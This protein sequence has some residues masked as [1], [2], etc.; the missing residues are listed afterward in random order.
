MEFITLS[1]LKDMEPGAVF[2]KGNDSDVVWLAVRGG[3]HDW[4]MYEQPKKHFK[5]WDSLRKR[6]EK[7][8]SEQT[9]RDRI[10]CDD[11]AWRMYRQ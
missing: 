3:T 8:F 6:G 2:A 10:E 11:A 4:A 7:I 1:K 5:S 9:I